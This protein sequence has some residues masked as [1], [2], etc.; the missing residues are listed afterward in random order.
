MEIAKELAEI[1]A[2]QSTNEIPIAVFSI[3][4]IDDDASIESGFKVPPDRSP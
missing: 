3:N 1:E 2:K 4:C